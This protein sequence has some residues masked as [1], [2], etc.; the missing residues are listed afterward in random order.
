MGAK[1]TVTD[2]AKLKQNVK[3]H[4]DYRVVNQTRI[5]MDLSLIYKHLRIKFI[6]GGLNIIIYDLSAD[7]FF[8]KA[9]IT[10][11]SLGGPAEIILCLYDMCIH[12]WKV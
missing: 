5:L 10:H 4:P 3:I 6:Y 12:N 8:T 2:Q 7:K 1:T 9:L 11:F